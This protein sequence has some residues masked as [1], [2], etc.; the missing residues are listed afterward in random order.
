MNMYKYVRLGMSGES[1]EVNGDR[2]HMS[3]DRRKDLNRLLEEGWRPIRETVIEWSYRHWFRTIRYPLIFIVLEKE[4][5]PSGEAG[6]TEPN[7]GRT[8]RETA[9]LS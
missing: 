7:A 1:V 5:G 4:I 9:T 3:D 8:V 6:I 2:L